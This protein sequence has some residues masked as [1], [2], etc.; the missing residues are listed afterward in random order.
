MAS[1]VAVNIYGVN[2]LLIWSHKT[3]V[4]WYFVHSFHWF[5]V[6]VSCVQI[7]SIWATEN[8]SRTMLQ[9]A[10]HHTHAR[11][12]NNVLHI[13]FHRRAL[14]CL[15]PRFFWFYLYPKCDERVERKER[16]KTEK[17]SDWSFCWFS[18]LFRVNQ[19]IFGLSFMLFPFSFFVQ[20]DGLTTTRLSWIS[21]SLFITLQMIFELISVPLCWKCE[22]NK[23]KKVSQKKTIP[24][25]VKVVGYCVKRIFWFWLNEIYGFKK[26]V[27][28]SQLM[29]RSYAHTVLWAQWILK[30]FVLINKC[31]RFL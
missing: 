23:E 10:I 25:T 20:C 5:L 31:G 18:V 7:P 24:K 26:W 30:W 14:I 4:G 12:H 15:W 6:T 8:R 21:I 27:G 1:I 22:R 28:F 13:L 29:A 9:N 16:K 19:N 2:K 17:R 11:M 3:N